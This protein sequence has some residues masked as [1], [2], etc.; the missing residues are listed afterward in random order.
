[1]PYDIQPASTSHYS[2]L[3]ELW[4]ASVRATHD[5]LNESDIQDYK[6]LILDQY[7][8]QLDLFRVSEDQHIQG[9]IGLDG[10]LVQMLFI[11]PKSRGLGVGKA[12]LNFAIERY[13]I[14]TVDV[15]EQNNQAVGFYKHLG[16]EIIE[17]FEQDATGKPYPILSMRLK[18]E[19]H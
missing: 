11:H 7:F 2:E 15:N 10:Q 3:I 19:R 4:E 17:R 5:F 8:D 14:N 18:P 9:F 16:F 13:G 1:M 6:P 12:L